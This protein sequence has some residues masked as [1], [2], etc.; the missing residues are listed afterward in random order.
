MTMGKTF[1]E[2]TPGERRAAV[3][4]AL[5]Q[6]QDE[7]QAAAPKIAAILDAA[8]RK[9]PRDITVSKRTTHVCSSGCACRSWRCVECGTADLVDREARYLTEPEGPDT[10]APELC[11]VCGGP[12]CD[13][14]LLGEL[15]TCPPKET[16]S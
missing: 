16:V 15:H 14:C 2:M 8:G 7:L 11:V 1:G 4:R 10:Y 3:E 13:R 12:V 9:L 6:L 5:D